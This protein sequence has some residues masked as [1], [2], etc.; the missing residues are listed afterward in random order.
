MSESILSICICTIAPRFGMLGKLLRTID[1]QISALNAGDLVEVLVEPAEGITTGAKRNLLYWRARGKYV[2]S[3]DDDDDV[4]PWYVEEI[5]K[6]ADQDPDA[7][8]MNGTMTTDGGLLETWDI[9]RLNPYST[10]WKAGRKR[11]Y[12]RYHNHLSPIRRTIAL[13]FPFPDQTQ[14]EDFVFATAI[15]KAKAIKTE[16]KIQR[17]MYHYKYIS[18]K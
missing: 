6:A 17:P 1:D 14:R 4:S 8:A 16:A 7:I 11:H 5:L 12:L 2:C 3:V 10:V 15:H 9:S 18:N 13:Q